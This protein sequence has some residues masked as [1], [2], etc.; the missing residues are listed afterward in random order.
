MNAGAI[1]EKPSIVFI[2]MHGLNIRAI[3]GKTINRFHIR[4]PG[5]VKKLLQFD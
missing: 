5:L 1:D 3:D 2:K 4:N